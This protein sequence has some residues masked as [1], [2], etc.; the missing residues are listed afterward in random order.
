MT[1]GDGIVDWRGDGNC[2]GNR[3]TTYGRIDYAK[4]TQVIREV[5]RERE[6]ERAE[7]REN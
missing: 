1:N 6:G 2:N 5:G 7:E 4:R 3:G